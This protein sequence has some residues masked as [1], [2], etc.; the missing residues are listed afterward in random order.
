LPKLNE[1][2][3]VDHFV[4]TDLKRRVMSSDNGK[5]AG[6]KECKQAVTAAKRLN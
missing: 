5:V 4:V 6:N 3:A 2:V 1:F